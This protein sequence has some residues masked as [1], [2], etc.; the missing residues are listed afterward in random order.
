DVRRAE[1]SDP[2]RFRVQGIDGGFVLKNDLNG[3]QLA[4]DNCKRAV[5]AV[6][7]VTG[8]V[9][10][11]DCTDCTIVVGPCMGSLF[12]RSSTNCKVFYVGQQF[13]MRDCK[14][15]DVAIYCR[16]Q[17]IIE[18][19]GNIRFYPL[20]LFY[21]D[22]H[23]HLTTIGMSAFGSAPRSIHDYTPHPGVRNYA[24][25]DDELRM[26]LASS[27]ELRASGISLDHN[28]S[29][30]IQKEYIDNI[31]NLV[32]VMLIS[33]Q[34][35]GESYTHFYINCYRACVEAHAEGMKVVNFNEV[36][37]VLTDEELGEILK[38]A[39]PADLKSRIIVM[40]VMVP[41]PDI[42]KYMEG[43]M[44]KEFKKVPL[45]YQSALRERLF[46]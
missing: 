36:A 32:K 46:T 43:P 41:P 12:I 28:D 16:T 21:P 33:V 40:E 44:G 4:I 3:Q 30:F 24:I 31:D 35:N 23:D 13:R 34:R 7:D 45:K 18:N 11:D 25:I 22:L 27:R 10:V 29:V 9:M 26:D 38:E 1:E 19:S 2:S 42:T 8:S 5:I 37:D 20:S 14:E 6:L 15:L 39:F 17:P